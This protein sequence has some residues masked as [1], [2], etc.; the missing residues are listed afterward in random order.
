MRHQL[1]RI[2]DAL[3]ALYGD[4]ELWAADLAES[5][6]S[7][8]VLLWFRS[9]EPGFSWI[10]SL[11]AVL[12]AA[13]MHLSLS[14]ESA[15]SE[16][17]MCLRMGFTALRR[18][19]QSLHWK[20]DADPSRRADPAHLRGVRL[21]GPARA[22]DRLSG[23]AD[24]PRRPGRNFRGWRVNYESLAY[25]MADR[26][27]APRAPWS[28]R[29]APP[30][31]RAHASEA[32]PA[33]QPEGK[34]FFDQ[35]HRPDSRPVPST[36]PRP[37]GA[38]ASPVSSSGLRPR[39]GRPLKSAPGWHTWHRTRG[40]T[41]SMAT[42]ELDADF[43]ALPLESSPVGCARPGTGA[44]LRARRGAHR[45]DPIAGRAAARRPASRPRPTTSSSASGCG[46]CTTGRSGS[47]PRSSSTADAAAAL[48]EE[49]VATA[50]ATAPA[51][52]E[53]VELAEEPSHGEA[54]WTS[55]YELD[56]A[57]V[58]DGRE[59]GAA[60]GLERP[61]AAS[62]GRG[63]R[64]R[65]RAR[66]RRG[67]ALRRS[68]RHRHHPA[69]GSR[70]PG[71]SRRSRSTPRQAGFESMRTLAPPA[72]RGWEYL[73][74]DGLGLGR[75]ARS[76]PRL[77]RREAPRPVGRPRRLRPGHRSHEP[78]AH[79]PRVDR[80][81]HRARP[82]DGLR[83]RLRRDVVRDLRQARHARATARRS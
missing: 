66:R 62:P 80:P 17:R 35:K 41:S 33:P 54:V 3:P 40:G 8:P 58:P 31:P 59:G 26:V 72:G 22:R 18:I 81:R 44:R 25:R 79:D 7:Y 67:Q 64:D 71:R 65:L 39:P 4:W 43:L 74:G 23:R 60:R 57:E 24:R 42:V 13:A 32:A 14:P 20:F 61:P 47:R 46:S 70:P 21:R 11:L 19:A 48:A 6:I 83:G 50:R 75:G 45:A 30:S 34:V 5:H 38:V 37:P 73:L 36:R 16:A 63:P 27:V 2:T 10:L 69:P 78:L 1:V 12:D 56:P 55:S 82:G 15:P 77:P 52:R 9:P 28:G 49:A 29:A 68:R 51:V 76:H 53:R